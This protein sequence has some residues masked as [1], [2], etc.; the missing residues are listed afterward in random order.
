MRIQTLLFLM[1][2]ITDNT[3]LYTKTVLLFSHGIA[4]TY[5]QAF[6]YAPSYKDNN[7]TYHNERFFFSCLF[8]T[9]DYPDATQSFL[10]VNYNETSF[11]Q[12]N[13][14]NC[15][16]TV[17][18]NTVSRVLQTSHNCSLILFGSSRGASNLTIFAGLHD[19]SYV[20][21]MVLESPYYTM[22]NVIQNGMNQLH[23]SWLPLSYGQSLAEFIFKKYSRCGMSPAKVLDS[24][25]KDI[26]I[27]IICSKEDQR[28]PYASSINMYKKLRL[29]GHEHT[30][31]LILDHGRHAKII[32]DVDGQ[33]YQEVV[34]AFYKKYNLSY[35][36]AHA[37]SG[38][39][40][41]MQC[42]PIL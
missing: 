31:I 42:Q 18:H 5:K 34:H 19:I 16:C 6:P 13:E 15:L 9:F 2:S 7:I 27:L 10:R 3:V 8:V 17:Y 32:C 14:I 28:V 38:E 39:K 22:D 29:S 33:K 11:G 37:D 35:S 24:I 36:S 25:P 21:A 40:Y 20:K 1:V 26:P 4:D 30:Y 41:L 23:L 12:E